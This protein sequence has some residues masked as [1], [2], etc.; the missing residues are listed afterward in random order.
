M[1]PKKV[2]ANS[3]QTENPQAK[4]GG[5]TK[6]ERVIAV[7]AAEGYTGSALLELLASDQFKDGYAKLVG[8]T[9]G[10]P[11][12]DTKA[13][14]EE[15]GVE[16]M[17]VDKVD[18][19]K[20]KEL[21]VDTLCL[22]PPAS[23]EKMELVKHVL[24]LGKKA[25]SVQNMVLVSSAGADYAERDKQPRLREFIDL[26]VLAMQPKSDPSTG[27]TGHSPCIVRAGFYME[28]LLLYSKQAQGEGQLPIPIDPDHKFAPV[29]LGDVALLLATILVSKGPHGLG[30]EVR[31]QLIVCTG[32]QL[33]AG[34]ELAEAASQALGTKLEFSSVTEAQAKKI[35]GSEGEELDDDSLVRDGKTNYVA[36]PPAF[37]MVTGQDLTLPTDWFQS[38][39]DSFKRKKRRTTK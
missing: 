31:G 6:S 8:L 19:N 32:P 23:K 38:Y 25:K 26:E 5:D 12:E 20:L 7:S 35:L 2:V 28:N 13:I 33:V 4:S 17:M 15:T 37:K 29:A 22:I 16:T 24:E 18:E 1:A 39:Q 30:D 34:P 11:K 10:E 36:S 27:D 14:L 21:G 3:E 9:F